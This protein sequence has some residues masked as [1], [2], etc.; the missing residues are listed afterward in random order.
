M[1]YNYLVKQH[2]ITDCAASCIATVCMYYKKEI[3]ITKLRDI[4]GT[5]IKGTTLLG[6]EDGAK[7]LGFDTRAIRV[8]KEGFKQKFTLPAIAHVITKEG[9]SHFVIVH[10]IK[11]EEVII[12]DPAKG[13]EKKKIDEFFKIFDGVLLLL[14]PNNEFN[15]GK[16][17]GQGI[18]SKFI[19][20][21]LP[22]KSLFI[23]SIVVSA[24]LTVLGIASAFFNKILMDEILPYNLKNQLNI[25][26]IGFLLL[27]IT[28]IGL[29]AIRQHMLLYLS[30]KIDIPLLLGY[31]K[32]VY[33]L[34]MK[35]FASRKVGDILTRFSDAFT[36]KNILTSVS[37]S[38]IMDIVLATVSASILYVMNQKLF[39]V[40]L[41]LT[42]V[43]AA[44]IYIFKGP[45][46]KINLE[47]MEAG[48]RLNSQ[49]IE[50]LKGI[51]TIKVHAAEEN[52]IEK[53][54]LEYIRN[55]K[56]AFK[57]G[58]LSNIQG[59]I[60]GAVS[61]VGN[62]IL[63]YIGAMMIMKGDITLGSL[64]AFSTLSGYFMDPIGR[65]IGLQLS[66]QEASIS[67]KRISEIYEVEKE[68]DET[69]VEKIKLEKIDGDIELNNI[70]FRYGSR[71]P[72]LNDVSIKIPK[73]KKVALVGES[74]S[75]KTTISKLLLK[76][77]TPEEGKINV[78]DYNIE[79]LDLYNLR[80]NIAYVPQNV[81][82]FSG[83]IK[84]N[85]TLGKTNASYEEIKSACENA[86]CREFIEKLP[87]K[88]GTFLEEAG[89]GLSGGE[90]QR[91][92]LA[93]ALIKKPSFLILDEATSNLDF[94]SE[95][96]IFDTLFKKGRNITMLMIAH[97][98]STIRSCDIIYVMDKGK[99][100]EE[101]NHES[102]LKKKGYYYKL[103]VSQVGSL[104]ER[105]NLFINDSTYE[106]NE[107][108]AIS[109]EE[110]IEEGEEYEY[111]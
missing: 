5:D 111:N 14:I 36:I 52:S 90:K 82:L 16:I 40:I 34:P 22:Q 44:L 25:F 61:S 71:S 85:I 94:I 42:I 33:K 97:R 3:T 45:Y 53:L 102:L 18:L 27:A 49:I 1:R 66:I 6:L 35:F 51:E 88:Y 107:K 29:G 84:E 91:I 9:L 48:A 54:E 62:L 77:Y 98:L 21:L 32:H 13:K 47:Q 89:G 70:T 7:K 31:F 19:Q 100:V 17:K 79:E 59:S 92:A 83:S 69:E 103:Y 24:I 10:K 93:R 58:V 11:K 78:N 26:V 68:Q 57:E 104:E 95:A 64:M 46:K 55:L 80:E 28:Q 8:D 67:L 105:D 65:L 37:L 63:M 96:K 74:G 81:E 109:H 39:V 56:I 76:Y 38:L 50:S 106:I 23:Y 87:G 99:I 2:D 43:S 4:L 12:L 60:S 15:P 75:G 20:L 86:G 30:Q 101:G 72:V 108:N 73:G 41:V 110:I